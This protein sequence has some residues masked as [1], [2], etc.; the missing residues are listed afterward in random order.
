MRTDRTDR[1]RRA[2]N[3]IGVDVG[4]LVA[5]ATAPGTFA[6]SLAARGAV[7]QG[8]VTALS[9]GLH[10]LLTLGAQDG[11]QAVAA[12]LAE[13]PGRSPAEALARQRALTV[14]ADLAAVPLGLGLRLAL[15]V[16]PGEPVLRGLLRQLGWRFAVAG[17]GGSLLT[18]A[19]AGAAEADA[20]AGAGGRIARFP[21]AVPVGLAV[22]YLLERRRLRDPSEAA[23][24]SP[25]PVKSL[26]LA[27]N[28]V[29][30]HQ[31]P[32]TREIDPE[33][34]VI[35]ERLSGS[36]MPHRAKHCRKRSAGTRRNVDICR[37]IVAGPAFEDDL[38]NG[39]P[40]A[41]EPA[42]GKRIQWSARRKFAQ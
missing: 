20:R 40:V 29:D 10:Y 33:T 1:A 12:A 30:Q 4:L 42:G 24:E 32:A 16:R 38:F 6:P 39:V 37:Y 7:D 41:F 28:V 11:L 26:A 14:V 18:A 23:V 31:N 3:D 34:L 5:S 19:R 27:G 35:F 2:A 25:S 15:P 21:L 13:G 8:L 22:A 9:A 36:P 17:L